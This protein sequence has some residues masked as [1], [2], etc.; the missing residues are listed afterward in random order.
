MSSPARKN[1]DVDLHNMCFNLGVKCINC[2]G[3]GRGRGD[4]VGDNHT[5]LTQRGEK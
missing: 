5:F 2:V 3:D 4:G 1:S